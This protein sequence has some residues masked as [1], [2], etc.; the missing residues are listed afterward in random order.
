MLQVFT[1]ANFRL[2]YGTKWF[3]ILFSI[4]A[5]A[6]AIGVMAARGFNYGIDFAGGTA[7][8]LKFREP[9]RVEELRSALEKSGLGDISIQAIGD[10]ADNEVLIRV[11]QRREKADSAGSQG[12]EAS[13]EILDALKMP[14]DR[15]A[16]QEGTIDLNIVSR[17]GLQEWLASRLPDPGP[18][19]DNAQKAAEAAEAVVKY[20]T[21]HGGLFGNLS[22]VASI[23]GIS[24]EAATVLSKAALGP[25]AL[26]GVE[27]VGPTAGRELL[28]DTGWL[29]LLSVLGILVYVWFRFHKWM[30]GLTAIIALVHDVIIA[31][32]AI[33]L[34]GKE[35]SL[36]VVAAL[37]TILGYSINDTIVVFDRIRENLRL[38]REVDFEDLVNASVNQTLSRTILTVFTVLIAITALYL[39]GGEKLNPMSFCLLVGVAFGSYSSV[40]V[41]SGLLVVVYRR[42]GPKFVKV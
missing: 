36:T 10:V 37:L 20:R 25:F 1:H 39:Y 41:A 34:T 6:A 19:A 9:P 29:I 24:P 15:S 16:A 18:G 23:P 33:S 26:R 17:S 28:L 14:V 7:V 11:E 32:G 2:M 21:E 8:Q 40:F 12:G 31:A 35:F 42:L 30:W 22:E 5:V 13:A 38:Y 3:F 27:F 4:L